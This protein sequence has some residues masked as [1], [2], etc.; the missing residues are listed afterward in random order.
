[1]I[2]RVQ[3]DSSNRD[4]WD[5]PCD[6]NEENRK[7]LSQQMANFKQN[8]NVSFRKVDLSQCNESPCRNITVYPHAD[9]ESNQDQNFN[10]TQKEKEA[11]LRMLI[12]DKLDS[13][14]KNQ[15]QQKPIKS[16]D[17]EEN[18]NIFLLRIKKSCITGDGK[19]NIDLE[20]RAPRPWLPKPIVKK[21]TPPPVEAVAESKSAE[22]GGKEGKGGKGKKG[23][24]GKK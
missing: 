22:N 20:F 24:K 18:P 23:K 3:K 12:D 17:L 11:D 8:E 19:Y 13:E 6:C 16:I 21:P 2:I 1:M 7:P 5:P 14:K 10:K 15:S 9:P 4:E